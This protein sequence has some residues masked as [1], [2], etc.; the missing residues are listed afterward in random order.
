MI[1]DLAKDFADSLASKPQEHP[2]DGILKLLVEA[3]HRDV[4]FLHYDQ[5]DYP[6]GLFRRLWNHAW[7]YDFHDWCCDAMGRIW[8]AS[9]D[10]PGN[11]K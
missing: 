6:Q 11:N 7:W 5:V 4:Y 1:F 9:T 2:R 10:F 3:L 8:A